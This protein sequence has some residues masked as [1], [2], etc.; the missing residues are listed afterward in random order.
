PTVS[1]GE[2]AVVRAGSDTGVGPRL[3]GEPEPGLYLVEWIDGTPLA[4]LADPGPAAG[5]AIGRVVRRLHALPPPDGPAHPRHQPR[6]RRCWPS[7]PPGCC[8]STWT[9]T[10][11]SPAARSRRGCVGWPTPSSRSATRADS[12]S[13]TCSDAR[14]REGGVAGPGPRRRPAPSCH[15]GET[16]R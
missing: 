10:S 4:A 15:G 8:S 9:R 14:R 16:A 13:A 6:P 11:P 12:S 2:V 7:W 1:A 5:A 3:V